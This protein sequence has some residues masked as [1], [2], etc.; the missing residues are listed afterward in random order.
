MALLDALYQEDIDRML[1]NGIE[2][3]GYDM[4]DGVPVRRTVA[5]DADKETLLSVCPEQWHTQEEQRSGLY[6]E[7]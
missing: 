1:A 6:F 4:V 3:V 7:I 2:G 5:P